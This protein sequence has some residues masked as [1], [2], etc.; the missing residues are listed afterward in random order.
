MKHGVHTA[1]FGA[2][3][4][5][6]TANFGAELGIKVTK[7]DIHTAH[8]VTELGIHTADLM[9]QIKAQP[10]ETRKQGDNRAKQRILDDGPR[11]V[12]RAL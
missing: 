3:L 8:F 9:M 5:I 11:G 6:H 4:G 12:Y 7:L 1:N 10:K 2:E